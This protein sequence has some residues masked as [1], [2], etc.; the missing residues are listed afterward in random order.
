MQSSLFVELLLHRLDVVLL[1]A[2]LAYLAPV[3]CAS[4]YLAVRWR[5]FPRRGAFWLVASSLGYGLPVALIV[6]VGIPSL[7]F[8][9]IVKHTAVSAGLDGSLLLV[10]FTAVSDFFVK[11][12]YLISVTALP[13]LA[14]AWSVVATIVVGRRWPKLAAALDARPS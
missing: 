10:P 6:I 12:W 11:Y 13:A 3:V 4:A 5:T 14:A 9:P 7:F 1:L 2:S 8:W